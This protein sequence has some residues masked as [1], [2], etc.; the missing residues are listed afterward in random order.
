MSEPDSTEEPQLLTTKTLTYHGLRSVAW[1]CSKTIFRTR[2]EGRENVPAEGPVVLCANHQS[3]L[4]IPLLAASLSRH[5]S[6]VAR[7]TL[8][9][10]GTLA[11]IMERCGA[12]LVK[13]GES[14][15]GALKEMIGHLAEGDCMCLFP[16]G[17]RTKDGSLGAFQRGALL[18]ARRGRATVVPVGISG[19]FGA[20]PPGQKYP[21]PHR[22]TIRFGEAVDPRSEGALEIVR[23][24]VAAAIEGR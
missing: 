1:M 11:R 5:V 13:R 9:K 10:S 4:D 24:R 2:V 12:V 6:F 3:F 21:R 7:D 17:T 23:Q 16:E 20:W 14:D 19:S 8:A 18:A 22:I 15:H